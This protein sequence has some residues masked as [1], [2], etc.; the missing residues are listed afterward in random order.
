MDPVTEA[1]LD[2]GLGITGNANRGGKRQVT[3]ISK[4][5][6]ERHMAALG[7]QLD[8]VNRRANL[9][10]SGCDLA[11]ARG[12][13]LR[14]GQTRITIRGETKPCNLM[15][16]TLPGLRATMHD[17]WGGGAFGEVVTGGGI[18]VGDDVF[19]DD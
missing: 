11:M 12:K 7:T 13:V 8:P 5:V 16:E 1:H 18:A 2:E 9:M 14:I 6:W 10:V 15:D 17:D 19:F 3:I 4:E